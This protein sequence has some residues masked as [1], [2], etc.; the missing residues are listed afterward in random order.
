MLALRGYG[1]LGGGLPPTRPWEG[2]VV[3]ESGVS[4]VGG[5][6][7]STTASGGVVLE[8]AVDCDLPAT[9][10][11]MR[12]GCVEVSGDSDPVLF[13]FAMLLTDVGWFAFRVVCE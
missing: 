2:A 8:L 4:V 1:S 9:R 13:L 11:L 10:K 5:G 6:V 12:F 7:C 3:G